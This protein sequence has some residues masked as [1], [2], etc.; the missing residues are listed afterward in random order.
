MNVLSSQ[1]SYRALHQ[2]FKKSCPKR[3][4]HIARIYFILCN[5]NKYYNSKIY[6]KQSS[7][8]LK[9]CTQINSR[10][11]K[12]RNFPIWEKRC[13]CIESRQLRMFI[14]LPK[15]IHLLDFRRRRFCCRCRSDLSFY[16]LQIIQNSPFK[17][18]IV[19]KQLF[20]VVR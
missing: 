1:A 8:K 17:K 15:A 10:V 16:R 5:K 14:K 11:L 12:G 20:L 3:N 7:E 19:R 13:I 4:A 6:K 18:S 2:T 9:V